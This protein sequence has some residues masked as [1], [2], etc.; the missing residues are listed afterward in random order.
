[1][2]TFQYVMIVSVYIVS[3]L[4]VSCSTSDPVDEDHITYER[5]IRPLYEERCIGCHQEG[6]I[7]PFRLDLYE[8]AKAS[9]ILAKAA[10]QSRTMPPWSVD[11]S[12]A[13]KTYQHSRELT[14]AQIEM[15]AHWIEDGL[16]EGDPA[17]APAPKPSDELEGEIITSKMPELYTPVPNSGGDDDRCFL[18]DTTF[19]R[20]AFVTAFE[21]VPGNPQVVHHLLMFTVDLEM[22]RQ[23]IEALD[24]ETPE[25]G[26]PCFGSAGE[27]V[28]PS[29]LAGIWTPGVRISRYPEGTGLTVKGGEAIVLQVH[30]YAPAPRGADQTE[31]RFSITDQVEK[32]GAIL[33]LDGLIGTAFSGQPFIIP[34]GQADVRFT[35]NT[36]E[37]DFDPGDPMMQGPIDPT[38]PY[39]VH[40][41][42]PHMH[43]IGRTFEAN[44]VGNGIEPACAT[45][46]DEYE[47]EWQEMYF[48][49]DPIQVQPGQSFEVTCGFDSRSRSAPTDP[50][51]GAEQEMCSYI[52]YAVQ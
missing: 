1:V 29:G 30:Y 45:R 51:F 48:F 25:A 17:D 42:F 8:D 14:D 11:N 37:D 49:E 52:L 35:W 33:L 3:I 9:A 12:G 23:T 13:C 39:Q 21:V 2:N 32:P 47:F 26:W 41:V 5:D 22:N 38:R 16:L 6:G 44:L 43:L 15:I 27:G 20:D 7:G 4:I 31:I 34:P 24:A 18:L 40:G 19:P 36:A 46:I 50:G 10:T 28:F